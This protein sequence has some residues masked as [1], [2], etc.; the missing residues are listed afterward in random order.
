MKKILLTSA[1]IF[2]F[3]IATENQA[4]ASCDGPYLA[5]RGGV[6]NHTLGDKDENVA[7]D[8]KL[9]IDDNSLMISGALGYRYKYFRIE[10]EYVWRKDSE[11][12]K[13]TYAKIPVVGGYKANTRTAE[14]SSKSY[15][16]NIYW[17]LSPYTMFTP[18][19]SAG[20]GITSLEYT[21]KMNDS[22]GTHVKYEED[23]FTWSVGGGLSAQVTSR[24]NID[25]G[26]RYYDMGELESGEVHNHE[27]YGGLR[28][29]F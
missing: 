21:F 1:A 15:M 5:V 26:Y 7:T 14:F 17:D 27:V 20:L 10:G 24:F 16:A 25:L 19:V 8:K 23:N 11:D 2:S 6:A 18:Y 3:L 9:D 28:Y 13:T 4:F 29:T 12:K 22:N